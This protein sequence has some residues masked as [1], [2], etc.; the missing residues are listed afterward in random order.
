MS[1]A[2]LVLAAILLVCSI[3]FDL[4]DD[5]DRKVARYLFPVIIA[6]CLLSIIV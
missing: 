3:L 4:L 1:I 2:C 5:G 6:L